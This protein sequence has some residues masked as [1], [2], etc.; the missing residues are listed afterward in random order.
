VFTRPVG[1]LGLQM[2]IK[3]LELI[4]LDISITL[5]ARICNF[6]DKGTKFIFILHLLEA[7]SYSQNVG[8]IMIELPRETALTKL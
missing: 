5:S 3:L 4:F 7:S 1:L 8:D 6:F 2:K